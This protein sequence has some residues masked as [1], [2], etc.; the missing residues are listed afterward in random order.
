MEESTTGPTVRDGKDDGSE[1]NS[2]TEVVSDFS[3]SEEWISS[4]SKDLVD[5]R[6]PTFQPSLALRL[7]LVSFNLF[8]V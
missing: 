6:S 8:R 5:I 3:D 1:S 4:Y 2:T 7:S